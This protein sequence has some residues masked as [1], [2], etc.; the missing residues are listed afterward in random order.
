MTDERVMADDLVFSIGVPS[1]KPLVTLRGDGTV[2]FGP[3]YDP[4][5]TA[6]AFWEGLAAR[7]PLLAEVERLRALLTQAEAE[8]ADYRDYFATA[9]PQ[10]ARQ[11][12]G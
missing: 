8:L 10:A 6:R 5:E 7:N 1:A 3:D 12:G 9:L 2:E 4:D 11:E